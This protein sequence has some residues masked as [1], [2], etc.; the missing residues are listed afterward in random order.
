MHLT[1]ALLSVIWAGVCTLPLVFSFHRTKGKTLSFI[2]T[3]AYHPYYLNFIV[4]SNPREQSS[5]RIHEVTKVQE[6]TTC[7]KVHSDP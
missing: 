1:S 2:P 6:Q 5:R 7:P 3:A 4:N